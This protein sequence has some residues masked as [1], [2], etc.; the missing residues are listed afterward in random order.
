M[1]KVTEPYRLTDFIIDHPTPMCLV[2]AKTKI[3]VNCNKEASAILQR[4]VKKIEGA[5]LADFF[6][7]SAKRLERIT[8]KENK[9]YVSLGSFNYHGKTNISIQISGKTIGIGRSK[10]YVLVLKSAHKKKEVIQPAEQLH[11]ALLHSSIVVR[12]NLEGIITFANKNFFKISGYKQPEII[13]ENIRLLNSGYHTKSFWTQLW[14]V[15]VARNSWKGEIKNKAKNGKYFWVETNITP[16]FDEKEN[17]TEYLIIQEDITDRKNHEEEINSLIDQFSDFN[18][19]VNKVSIISKADKRG[20][21]T[22]VNDNFSKISGYKLNELIGQNHN[23]INS[24]YHPKSFWSDMWKTIAKGKAWRGEVKNKTKI[25]S[26]YWVD[27]FILPLLDE[28]GNIKEYLS[29]RNDITQ[30]KIQEEATKKLARIVNHTTNAIIFTDAKGYTTWVNDGFIQLTGYTLSEVL[31]KKPGELLQGPDTDLA[32]VKKMS[33]A[34]EKGDGFKVEILNYSKSKEKYWLDVEVIPTYENGTLTGFIAIEVDITHLKEAYWEIEKKKL[35]LQNL[36][37][38]IPAGGLYQTTHD[39]LSRQFLFLGDGLKDIFGFTAKDLM[40]NPAL[41]MKYVHPDDIQLL[42]YSKEEYESI[43]IFDVELRIL[44]NNNKTKW[45]HIRSKL[46]EVDG[47]KLRDGFITDITDRKRAELSLLQSEDRFKRLIQDVN[48]G[49]LL[50]GP[51][52]EILLANNASCT[53]L[54]LS[55]NELLGKKSIDSSWRVLNENG[56]KISMSDLPVVQAIRDKKNTLGVMLQVFRDKTNDWIWLRVDAMPRIDGSG[57]VENVICVIYDFTAIKKAEAQARENEARFRNLTE[58]INVGVLLQDVQDQ[59][60]F[61]NPAAR[62]LLGITEDQLL[63]KSSFDPDWQVVQKDGSPFL[64]EH[65]PSVQALKTKQKANSVQMGVYRPQSKDWVW[66]LTSAMPMLDENK[67]VK[68]VIVSMVD[69]TEQ[70]QLEMKN[71]EQTQLLEVLSNIQATFIT[72][73]D[74]RSFFDSTLKA[75]L[76]LTESNYGFIGEVLYDHDTP[77]LKTHAITNIAWNEE[78]RAFYNTHAPNGMEFRNLS[79]LFGHAMTSQKPVVANNPYHDPRRGGLPHG[80]PALNAFLGIPIFQGEKMVG[81]IGLANRPTGYSEAYADYLYPI[82]RTLGNIIHSLRTEQFNKQITKRLQETTERLNLTLAST[83]LGIWEANFTNSTLSGNKGVRQIF[84][85]NKEQLTFDEFWEFIHPDD[86]E[87]KI[88]TDREALSGSMKDFYSE[89]RIIRSNDKSIRHIKSRGSFFKD[90]TGKIIAGISVV[91]DQTKDKEYEAG[92]V[93][94]LKEKESLIKEIHHRVK[95]NLQ[96]ISS[97]LYLKMA[98]WNNSDSKEFISAMREKI[99]S[100]SLIHERLLQ[101]ESLDSINIKDYLEKLIRDIFITYQ[102][103]DKE[104]SIDTDIDELHFSSDYATYLGQLVN[105]L[106]INAMKHAF[107]DSK[108]GQIYVSLAKQEDDYTLIVKDSG[109]GLPSNVNPEKAK[110]YGMQL[111]Q[112]FVKQLKGTLH[113]SLDNGAT[114]TIT[115]KNQK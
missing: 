28:Q 3:I 73:Q 87:H 72:E 16:I 96:L 91:L 75:I 5:L 106:I 99:K 33:Q 61:S 11:E 4:T 62:N 49:I 113:Y 23:L 30:N 42:E 69:I 34:I 102:R 58:E 70:R 68:Q 55:E 10:F 27:T 76:H 44:D 51:S 107:N 53:L 38:N 37:D 12:T 112:I 85:I 103:N 40:E 54:G 48:V 36:A 89:Y 79:S 20:I 32:T 93:R 35:D 78:T 77:Y 66:L 18:F 82:N 41:L 100:V 104:I 97:M 6:S 74:T 63:G 15:L 1:K 65:R 67:D 21:I 7:I 25:G 98:D 56:E 43:E 9:K 101:T 14:K 17:L 92:L 94:S 84:G 60:L 95:N 105:E 115:F 2:D 83:G 45:V 86:R 19:A 59:I 114:Y 57:K 110:S 46:R 52:S 26:F 31:G 22:Y 64:P 111:I 24:G 88:K 108:N 81:M 13:G 71:Q 50:Q 109:S 47:Q 8:N 29:V 39:G 80:H 90:D